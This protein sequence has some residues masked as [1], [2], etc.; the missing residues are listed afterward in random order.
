MEVIFAK[1]RIVPD[2]RMIV[3]NFVSEPTLEEKTP[4]TNANEDVLSLKQASDAKIERL[5]T[6]I[7]AVTNELEYERETNARLSE[8]TL[9][10]PGVL[11]AAEGY[12]GKERIYHY[13]GKG[14][15]GATFIYRIVGG[16]LFSGVSICSAADN[17]DKSEGVRIAR[18]RM[19]Q[20][21]KNRNG[22]P[23]SMLPSTCWIGDHGNRHL[24][25]NNDVIR[26]IVYVH[27][28]KFSRRFNEYMYKWI[29]S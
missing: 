6:L 1:R 13:R 25:K 5:T 3:N 22:A 29:G 27:S 11:D 28:L 21:I 26:R 15:G 23:L 7:K 2:L 4:M 12:C 24:P 8:L 17:F 10:H 20:A 9:T 19:M 14:K 18:E 16:I